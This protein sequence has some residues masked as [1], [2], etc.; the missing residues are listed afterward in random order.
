MIFFSPSRVEAGRGARSIHAGM[1]EG[2]CFW[3]K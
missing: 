2:A 3:K 1:C